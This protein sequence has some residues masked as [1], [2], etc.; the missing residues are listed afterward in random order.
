MELVENFHFAWTVSEY[1]FIKVGW[2]DSQPP[3]SFV[4]FD[5]GQG[6]GVIILPDSLDLEWN[7]LRA[8]ESTQQKQDWFM[9][10]TT[11]TQH[12]CR[13][14]TLYQMRTLAANSKQLCLTPQKFLNPSH[15]LFPFGPSP[16]LQ[17]A[18]QNN[19]AR[20]LMCMQRAGD[21]LEK[22]NKYAWIPR[23]TQPHSSP[24]H[25]VWVQKLL[26]YRHQIKQLMLP[27]PGSEH[28]TH[29]DT[30]LVAR[31]RSSIRDTFVFSKGFPKAVR[32][33]W[34]KRAKI[35]NKQQ[36][37][38]GPPS[39]FRKRL[40]YKLTGSAF[41]KFA[42]TWTWLFHDPTKTWYER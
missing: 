32:I 33:Y 17:A 22:C 9:Q 2:G 10:M 25:D 24:G 23:G 6:G 40:P 18:P 20:W 28:I 29:L 34:V 4:V 8:F 7:L 5:E 42:P 16:F 35:E 13:K 27:S 15:G 11:L 14:T 39:L 37:G 36:A 26:K 12:E 31:S 21:T 1:F 30:F 41:G 3:T 19:L 38:S